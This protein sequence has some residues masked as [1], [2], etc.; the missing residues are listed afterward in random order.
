MTSSFHGP[1][2]FLRWRSTDF[3]CTDIAASRACSNYGNRKK[4]YQQASIIQTWLKKLRTTIEQTNTKMSILI[5]SLF[6]IKKPI[7]KWKNKLRQYK[8]KTPVAKGAKKKE[9]KA[10]KL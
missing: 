6:L 4:M 2:V 5:L 10:N 7:N 8:T 1:L 3:P 9:K